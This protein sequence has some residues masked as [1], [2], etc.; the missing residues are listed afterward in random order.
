V[1]RSE[2]EVDDRLGQ[3]PGEQERARQALITRVVGG[4]PAAICEK[5]AL[6]KD[7]AANLGGELRLLSA[8]CRAHGLLALAVEVEGFAA[9]GV[10]EKIARAMAGKSKSVP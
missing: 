6:L 2:R 7:D 9:L 10:N 5:L 4:D 8:T 1:Q 3:H